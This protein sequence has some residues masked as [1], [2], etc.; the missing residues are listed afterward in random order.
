MQQK[1]QILKFESEKLLTTLKNN[2][3]I[4]Q[5]TLKDIHH[6]KIKLQMYRLPI[7]SPSEL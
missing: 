7:N 3:I 6:A 4:L 5:N 1:T 2:I